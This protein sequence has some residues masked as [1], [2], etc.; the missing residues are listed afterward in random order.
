MVTMK[1]VA[2]LA[3]V[4]LITVSRVVNKSGYVGEATRKKVEAAIAELN[5]V[6]N[7]LASNLR[8]QQSDILALVLPDITNSFWTTIARG[9]E[10][11]A[12]AQGYSVFICNTDNDPEKEDLYIQR[13]MQRRVEGVLLVPTPAR[14]TEGQIE[15]LRQHGAKFV[16]IH[17]RMD[18]MIA[19][20][21]RSDGEGAAR[22]LTRELL[23]AGRTRLAFV[24]LSLTDSSSLE[25]LKGFR[26]ALRRAGH[27]V[28]DDLIRFGNTVKEP[29]GER[30]V[31]ELFATP[32]PPDGILLANSRIAIS[33]LRAIN[34]AGLRV[35]EDITVAAFHDISVMDPYAP[36]L[37]TAVQPSYRMGQ[38][39]ARL[40]MEMKSGGEG[41]FKEIILESRIVRWQ[42]RASATATR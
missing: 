31:A 20:V 36:K 26:D 14:S 15:R 32:N 5:Y 8:S 22:A 13:L 29:H 17:R 7:M 3:G 37:I 34:Q 24:G 6:P 12:W 33:G 23:Q 30:V 41:P 25:R 4:S 38:L 42:D 16:V 39:A 21:V 27:E 40:V 35:P 28:D 2:E 19:N 10:D 1:D 18:S 11:E 9:V